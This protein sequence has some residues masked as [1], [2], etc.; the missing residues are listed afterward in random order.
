[1]DTIVPAS[2]WSVNNLNLQGVPSA[3]PLTDSPNTL[4]IQSDLPWLRLEAKHL[5]FKFALLSDYDLAEYE[6]LL[7]E[8]GSGP[9]ETDY[10]NEKVY[11]VTAAGEFDQTAAEDLNVAFDDTQTTIYEEDLL[12]PAYPSSLVPVAKQYGDNVE[13]DLLSLLS[14][15]DEE[16]DTVADSEHIIEQTEDTELDDADAEEHAVE[17]ED[18]ASG[19]HDD[20][21]TNLGELPELETRNDSSAQ[22]EEFSQ[23]TLYDDLE[24]L[25]SID[26]LYKLSATTTYATSELE[27]SSASEGDHTTL[28]AVEPAGQPSESLSDEKELFCANS[29]LEYALPSVSADG[30]ATLSVPD[31]TT[32]TSDPLPCST[33]PCVILEYQ[34][35]FYSLFAP[36]ASDPDADVLFR[37]PLDTSLWTIERVG[38]E[39]SEVFGIAVDIVIE[40][41]SLELSVSPR[42]VAGVTMRVEEVVRMHEALKA[43]DVPLK[44][45]LLECRNSFEERWG[46]LQTLVESRKRKREGDNDG[47][48]AQGGVLKAARSQ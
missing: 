26:G 48:G 46:Y 4:D 11:S 24:D 25:L 32:E 21:F 5:D 16:D 40:F 35:S 31:P 6:D 22:R 44:M 8:F 43:H 19:L 2:L 36:F 14:F 18:C 13:E 23:S 39:L 15:I 28:S 27:T 34:S 7:D 45:L 30:N 12:D 42:T 41:P 3:S 1:M 29:P 47:Y 37:S 17:A 9:S 38:R 33:L 10:D 20:D